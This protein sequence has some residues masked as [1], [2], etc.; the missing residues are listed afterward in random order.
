M[1]RTVEVLGGPW[2]AP[3]CPEN[4]S[5]PSTSRLVPVLSRCLPFIVVMQP[6]HL[7]DFPD[8]ANLWPLDRPWQMFQC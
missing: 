8:R 2:R 1:R 6:T 5:Q 4:L 3:V 7:W